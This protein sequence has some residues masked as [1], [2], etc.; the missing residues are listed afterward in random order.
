MSDYLTV[1][2]EAVHQAGEVLMQRWGH[3]S[4]RHKGPADLVTE[5]DF[6][7]QET[8]RQIIHSAFPDHA[9]I[10][11]EDQPSDGP[12]PPRPEFRWIVDPLD[13]T[14]NYVHGVPFF[15]VS[16]ALEHCGQLRAAAIHNPVSGE[17]FSAES[18]RGAFLNG[19]PIHVSKVGGL[20][21][22]LVSAGF[23]ALVTPQASDLLLFND[24][25]LKCQAIRRTGSAAL[26][27]AFL[28]AGRFDAAWSYRTKIWDVAAGTLLIREAG[29]TVT[30]P[31][32]EPVAIP[33]GPILAAATPQLHG[34]LLAIALRIASSG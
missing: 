19:S 23:P 6:A 16:L 15:C 13:G 17:C 24:V 28:A 25:V 26:N 29:G 21:E 7:A 4:V 8:V 32:G 3:V 31:R 20:S 11:E 10:G 2:R 27:L 5:A 14:T 12:P 34:E 1:C 33:G 18:Q 9:V 30:S 22:S